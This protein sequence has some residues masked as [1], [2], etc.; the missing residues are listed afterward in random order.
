MESAQVSQP[1]NRSGTSWAAQASKVLSHTF[2]IFSSLKQK[3]QFAHFGRASSIARLRYL[4]VFLSPC[5]KMPEL[6]LSFTMLATFQTLSNSSSTT[7][8]T[9]SCYLGKKLP[10]RLSHFQ[11]YFVL[12]PIT[13]NVIF[14]VYSKVLHVYRPY[15]TI[16]L[17]I[18]CRTKHGKFSR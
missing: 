6:Y 4:V 15:N 14:I 9:V 3:P 11:K 7:H 8:P 17:Y 5:R 13:H 1:L 12:S 2:H 16:S 18:C 10:V